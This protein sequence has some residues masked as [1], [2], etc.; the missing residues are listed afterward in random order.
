MEKSKPTDEQVNIALHNCIVVR[1]NPDLSP[2]EVQTEVKAV[3][4][5]NNISEAYASDIVNRPIIPV[6]NIIKKAVF[7]QQRTLAIMLKIPMDL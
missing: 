3:L 1:Q 6:G 7:K 4:H 2:E 5:A